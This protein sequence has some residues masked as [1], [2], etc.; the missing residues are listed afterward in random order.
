VAPEG[1][2]GALPITYHLGPGPAKVR[3]SLAFDWKRVPA[4]NVI[5]IQRGSE[6]PDQWVVRGNHHD[7]WVNGATDPSSGMAAVLAEAKA[8]SALVAEGLKP[9]RTIVFAA[10]DGE[11]PGLLGSTEWVEHHAQ[12]LGAKAVAYVN[13]DSNSRGYLDMAGSHSLQRLMNEIARDVMHY[14]NAQ[15]P[16]HGAPNRHRILRVA[17]QIVHR[18]IERVHD[19]D[20]VARRARRQIGRQ[21]LADDPRAG[22]RARERLGDQRLGGAV[23]LRHEIVAAL[24]GPVLRAGARGG[25]EIGGGARRHLPGDLD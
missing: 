12:E 22:H 4:H 11:E 8:L 9:R 23:H 24:F 7:A 18:P 17:V 14:T 25:A 13:S 6:E 2:R 10:W 5:A 15:R 16:A 1:W 20:D 21:L 3:L 19:P